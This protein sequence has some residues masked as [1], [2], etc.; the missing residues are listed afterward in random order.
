MLCEKDG[1]L[2]YA[3]VNMNWESTKLALPR[4]PK[5]FD[6]NMILST[7]PALTDKKSVASDNKNASRDQFEKVIPGRTVVFYETVKT[8]IKKPAAEKAVK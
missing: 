3:A 7:D 4:P 1:R 8:E 5:G 6:W 2:L